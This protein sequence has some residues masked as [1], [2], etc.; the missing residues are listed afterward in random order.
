MRTVN[1]FNELQELVMKAEATIPVS[2]QVEGYE[3]LIVLYGTTVFISDGICAC[4]SECFMNKNKYLITYTNYIDMI[5]R[6]SIAPIN[7]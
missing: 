6:S 1:N 3:D 2:F 7:S 4:M 5:Y